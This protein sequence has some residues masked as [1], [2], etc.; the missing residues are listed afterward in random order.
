M[1]TLRRVVRLVQLLQGTTLHIAEQHSTPNSS[2][3]SSP[4]PTP[5]HDHRHTLQL[6]CVPA[7]T[8]I[9]AYLTLFY[10]AH[11]YKL[12]LDEVLLLLLRRCCC[13]HSVLPLLG[14]CVPFPAT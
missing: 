4:L 8:S 7:S 3:L 2:V 14:L 10:T 12:L 11:E 1:L 9:T 6:P 5:Q 13:C